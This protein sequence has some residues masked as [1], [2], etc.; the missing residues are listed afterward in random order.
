LRLERAVT[1]GEL[2]RVAG[3]AVSGDAAIEVFGLSSLERARADELSFARSRALRE[4]A[5]ASGAGSLLVTEDFG[6]LDRPGLVAADV[7]SALASVG[8]FLSERERAPPE[9]GVHPTAILGE[10]VEIG[11]GASV[12]PYAVL[13]AGA[14]VGPRAR[15]GAG[16]YLGKGATVG[17]DAVIHPHA[18]VC[19]GC[20]IGARCVVHSGAVVGA[21][22]FGFATNPDGSYRKIPQLGNVVLEDDVEIGACTCIDRATIDSTVI[23]RGAKLDNL[24]HIAHNCYVGEGTAMAAQ[25][26][27]AGSTRIGSGCRLGG[28]AGITGHVRLGDG[29]RVGAATPVIKS[30]PDGMEVWGFP[31]REKSRAVREM[32]GAAR[33]WKLIE[34]VRALRERVRALEA[35]SAASGDS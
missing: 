33:S 26:G 12:G 23:A 4:R 7:D 30:I 35:G 25:V 3:A 13:E 11:E 34:E 15:V 32:A 24:I 29:V 14:S 6:D 18:T 27:V 21:D 2:A 1:L 9:A 10:G 22:G 5:L 28:Q 8:E 20:R 16:A 31:A 17:A 19:W